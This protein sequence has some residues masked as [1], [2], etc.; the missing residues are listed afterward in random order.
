[1]GSSKGADTPHDGA[2]SRGIR[3]QLR[4]SR[5]GVAS[6]R[7]CEELIAQ[8][9]VQVNGVVVHEMGLRVSERDVV[10][11]D[12]RPL[13]SPPKTVSVALHKPRG[14]ICTN[15]DPEGRPLAIDLLRDRYG[16]RLFSIGRLDYL[17]S[18]LIL[19]TNDGELARRVGHPSAQIEKEYLVET[20]IPVP[21]ELLDRF[22]RGITIEGTSYRIRR[23]QRRSSTRVQL[24]LVEGKNR[25]IRNLFTASH[26]PVTRIHRIRIGGVE[27]GRL[28]PGGHRPLTAAEV[29]SLH[30]PQGKGDGR[31]H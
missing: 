7:A 11:L 2:L 14:Y 20:K 24:V 27:L 26:I 29:A 16:A 21:V 15:S 12:G 22:V 25:E 13:R 10:L 4:L 8:G 17:S 19:Y 23:Y 9:R 6:R 3:L 5:S 1:M 28:P 31:R 30:Q 18:G